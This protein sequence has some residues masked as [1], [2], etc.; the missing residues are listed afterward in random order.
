MKWCFVVGVILVGLASSCAA[1]TKATVYG[2]YDCSR[3]L[4]LRD[5][6]PKAW[7]LGYLTG[8]D[9]AYLSFNPNPN[10]KDPLNG[11][12]PAQIFLYID[13]YCRTNPREHV[14]NALADFF[15]TLLS[16]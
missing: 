5:D 4:T 3:W 13:D 11:R 14:N 7:A 16:K 9:D 8:A 10:A 15:A 6:L 1:Q 2:A 12:T